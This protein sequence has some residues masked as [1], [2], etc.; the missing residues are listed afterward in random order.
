MRTT[1]LTLAGLLVAGTALAQAPAGGPAPAPSRLD[2]LLSQWEQAMQRAD[3]VIFTVNRTEN[4]KV[5]GFVDNYEGQARFLRTKAGDLASIHLINT[6]RKDSW[7]KIV[8]TDTAIHM[9]NSAEKTLRTITF[10][11]RTAGAAGG[12]ADNNA[13]GL[14]MGM[15]AADAKR[16]YDLRLAKEDEHYIYVEVLPRDTADK[17]DFALAQLT[18]SA[19]T[20][21]PR[22]LFFRRPNGNETT[23]DLPRTWI[24]AKETGIDPKEFVAPIVP[25]DWKVEKTTLEEMKNPSARPAAPAAPGAPAAGP[26]PIK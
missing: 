5:T 4:N 10:P 1:A 7:E 15:K 24:G 21:M 6:A 16:R 3:A 19:K 12:P 8:V 17:E 2:M 14:M 23:L 9:A 22:R 13:V 25:K 20:M 18:L 26:M 11:P